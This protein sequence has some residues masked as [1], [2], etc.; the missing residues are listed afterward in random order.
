MAVL[1]GYFGIKSEFIRTPKFNVFSK[2][3]EWRSN[4]YIKS[5][6]SGKIWIELALILYF[7]FGIYLDFQMKD[8]SYFQFHALLV[9]GYSFVFSKSISQ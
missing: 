6:V 1:E 8:F 3:D 5:R 7:L 9:L 4:Q 2:N